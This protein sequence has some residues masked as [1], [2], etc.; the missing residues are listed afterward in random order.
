M[1]EHARRFRAQGARLLRHG[2]QPAPLP[3]PSVDPE[4]DQKEG[5]ALALAPYLSDR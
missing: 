4:E 3:W 2:L 5:A 1:R